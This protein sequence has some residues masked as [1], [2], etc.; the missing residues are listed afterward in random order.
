MLER[1]HDILADFA[2]RLT[3]VYAE[4]DIDTL[5]NEWD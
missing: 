1:E 4:Y 5:R 3:G 2:G